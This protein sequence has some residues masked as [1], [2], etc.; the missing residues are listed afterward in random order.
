MEL[1]GI[2]T[3]HIYVILNDSRVKMRDAK[4]LKHFYDRSIQ[5]LEGSSLNSFIFF[6]YSE[7]K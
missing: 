1:V 6:A 5:T 2:L 3:C 4:R 7:K